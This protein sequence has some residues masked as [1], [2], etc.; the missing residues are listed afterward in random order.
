MS[1]P[2]LKQMGGWKSDTAVEGYFRDSKCFKVDNAAMI[3]GIPLPSTTPQTITS[4]STTSTSPNF[5]LS[6]CSVTVNY[7][8]NVK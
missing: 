1:M 5:T 8:V 7:N 6:N 3:A 4:T 2:N